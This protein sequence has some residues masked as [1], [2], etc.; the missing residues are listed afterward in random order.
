[1]TLD[2]LTLTPLLACLPVL[3]VAG[4]LERPGEQARVCP[5]KVP[6]V[7]N[8]IFLWARMSMAFAGCS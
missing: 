6:Q 7:R 1:M 8:P 4:Q 5:P 2:C 3:P